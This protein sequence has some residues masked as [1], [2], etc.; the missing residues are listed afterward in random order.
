MDK[1]ELLNKK[2][3]LEKELGQVNKELWDYDVKQ[4][5]EQY[6]DK[7]NCEFCR[8][9]AVYGF[10]GD[11]W[12]NMCGADNCTCCHGYCD[13]YKPDN[14]ATLKIKQ[15]GKQDGLQSTLAKISSLKFSITTQSLSANSTKEYCAYIVNMILH[16]TLPALAVNP[17]P[18]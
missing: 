3:E 5:A 11:G 14:A 1:Q 4:L 15:S 2:S 8:Y 7:F 6:K 9:N 13:K 12:H 10:S 18:N 17:P 16:A